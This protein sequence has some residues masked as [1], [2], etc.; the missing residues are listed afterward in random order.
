MSTIQNIEQLPNVLVK[1]RCLLPETSGVYFVV[2]IAGRLL[3]IG[4]SRNMR[5]RWI[6]NHHRIEQLHPQ[7]AKIHWMELS[8]DQIDDT[9]KTLIAHFKPVLNGRRITKSEGENHAT[10]NYLG[11]TMNPQITLLTEQ[12]REKLPNTR[13]DWDVLEKIGEIQ[14]WVSPKI[15]KKISHREIVGAAITEYYER[16]K[17]LVRKGENK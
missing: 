12:N 1:N 13:I 10:T 2:T 15:G 3:Y 4:K 6:T 14:E 16:L 8:E 17:K 9:E 11:A 5:Q 7:N